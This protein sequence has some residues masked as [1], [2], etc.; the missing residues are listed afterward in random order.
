MIGLVY[1]Q[2]YLDVCFICELVI[3]NILLLEVV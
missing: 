2:D 3:V 1:F